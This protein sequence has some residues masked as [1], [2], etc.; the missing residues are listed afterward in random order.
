M[1]VDW[2]LL[3]ERAQRYVE[4]GDLVSVEAGGAPTLRVMRL[5]GARAWV[6]DERT[7]LD[8][9]APLSQFHWKAHFYPM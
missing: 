1:R 9:V 5:D 8:M 2:E 7:E 4:V 3:D 6:R